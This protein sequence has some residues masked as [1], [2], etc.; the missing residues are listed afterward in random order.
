MR[1]CVGLGSEPDD[2]QS[3]KSKVQSWERENGWTP[4][5]VGRKGGR[6]SVLFLRDAVHPTERF[7][8]DGLQPVP[9]P[10]PLRPKIAFF[11][12]SVRAN[13]EERYFRLLPSVKITGHAIFTVANSRCAPQRTCRAEKYRKVITPFIRTAA[14]N[15]HRL[16]PLPV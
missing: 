6:E 1:F 10:L 2:V 7:L 13:K 14:V 11:L 16:G 9:F 15:H 8:V 3:L 5:R 12:V 4:G